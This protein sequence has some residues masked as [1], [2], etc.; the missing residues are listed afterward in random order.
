MRLSPRQLA[1]LR[2]LGRIE[3][4]LQLRNDARRAAISASV[5]YKRTLQRQ[6]EKLPSLR[7]RELQTPSSAGDAD[8][9]DAKYAQE[10]RRLRTEI[11]AAGVELR[12]IQSGHSGISAILASTT[13]LIERLLRY[14][15]LDRVSAG[16]NFSPH[17]R[18][19]TDVITLGA[20]P[21]APKPTAAA[22]ASAPTN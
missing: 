6:L 4:E 19:P 12:Q 21:A 18:L 14:A 9:I 3:N 2:A 16:L 1:K 11:D 5:E 22:P 20:R 7:E 17:D 15:N 10:E 8:R 13:E